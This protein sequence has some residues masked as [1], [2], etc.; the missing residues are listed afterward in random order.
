VSKILH[1][2]VMVPTTSGRGPL[3]PLSVGSILSQTVA[4]IE[5][6]IMG[7]GVDEA[8]RRLIHEMMRCDSRIRFFDNPK[9]ERRGE[10]YRHAALAQARGR[11]V[12]YL[13]DR[14]LMMPNHLEV[15][16][17]LLQ[18]A[19]FAHTLISMMMPS[20]ELQFAKA[21]DIADPADCR[22]IVQGW[23]SENGIPLS[24]GGHSMEM[25]RKLPHGWRT[26]PPQH[27][28]DIYM[29]EQFLAQG[30]SRG[31]SGNVPTILYFA[32]YRR[33]TWSVEQKREEI[34][35][36]SEQLAGPSWKEQLMQLVIDGL[37]RDRL[38]KARQIRS[39]AAG[40]RP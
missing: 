7:D 26:T 12:C 22:W 38:T 39:L 18:D 28:T 4:D 33:E 9:H 8:T 20:G 13:C 30:Q 31:R 25:Y 11:F 40:V 37:A 23:C 6:F 19:D 10:P 16:G 17:Q 34:Q 5:V 21:I 29:W 24:F 2:T 3:L 32:K 27:H 1:A 15:M 14:D 36:W 35:R